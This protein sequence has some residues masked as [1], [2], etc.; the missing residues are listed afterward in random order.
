[1]KS[2]AFDGEVWYTY[3]EAGHLVK[4]KVD[5][6]LSE[7]QQSF[8]FQYLPTVLGQM[9]KFPAWLKEVRSPATVKEFVLEV[10]FDDFWK[11]YFTGRKVDNSSKQTAQKRWERMTKKEQAAAYDYVRKYMN[12][13]APGCGVKL[14]ETYLN[15]GLWNN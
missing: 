3:D 1:M 8:L 13:I 15:S 5:A 9:L 4:L 10:T 6:E 11:R 2:S 12:N 7:Y 14:A